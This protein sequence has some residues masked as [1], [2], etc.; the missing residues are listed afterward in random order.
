MTILFL[1]I[2]TMHEINGRD[3]MLKMVQK[4]ALKYEPFFYF[5]TFCH[6]LL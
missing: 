2:F 4:K 1:I 6:E 5:S 3:E